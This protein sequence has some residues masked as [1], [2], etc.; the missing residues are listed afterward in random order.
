MS[1]AFGVGGTRAASTFLS[2]ASGALFTVAHAEKVVSATSKIGISRSVQV[3]PFFIRL[4]LSLQ[5][6]I[7]GP[8]QIHRPLFQLPKGFM[9]AGG[10]RLGLGRPLRLSFDHK[11]QDGAGG[12]KDQDKHQ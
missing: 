12:G 4:F 5:I 10:L 3:F 1:G 2:F 9:E 8:L 7:Q 6:P 11:H